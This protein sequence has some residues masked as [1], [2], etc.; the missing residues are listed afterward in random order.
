[1]SAQVM[2]LRALA[3]GEFQPLGADYD[4]R[5]NVRGSS[6]PPTGRSSS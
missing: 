2:L 5:V 3:S 4:A 1:M 6:P